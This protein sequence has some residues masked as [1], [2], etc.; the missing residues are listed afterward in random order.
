MKPKNPYQAG[1]TQSPEEWFKQFRSKVKDV[2][3]DAEEVTWQQYCP[4]MD[5]IVQLSTEPER[6]QCELCIKEKFKK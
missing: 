3:K 1:W 4:H 2:F 6:N 5:K